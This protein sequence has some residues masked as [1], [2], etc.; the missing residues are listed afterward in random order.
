MPMVGSAHGVHTSLQGSP[1]RRGHHHRAGL[2]PNLSLARSTGHSRAGCLQVGV[3][4]G[5]LS[6]GLIPTPTPSTRVLILVP[7][8]TVWISQLPNMLDQTSPAHL[9]SS[10][11]T[12]IQGK[13]K[14]HPDTGPR[15]PP[16]TAASEPLLP[17]MP[18]SMGGQRQRGSSISEA[19]LLLSYT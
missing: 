8:T 15:A 9:T 7:C 3:A 5:P 19:L 2:H 13:G 16:S 18:S 14:S 12:A 4:W 11:C 17:H 1:R 10:K 6:P